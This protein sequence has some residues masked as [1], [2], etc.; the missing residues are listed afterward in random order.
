[1]DYPDIVTVVCIGDPVVSD[2]SS[3]ETD[4]LPTPSSSAELCGG[5][6]VVNTVDL[7]DLVVIGLRGRKQAVKQVSML[8]YSVFF[9]LNE[10][11]NVY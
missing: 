11:T 1:M 2:L 9:R 10:Y 6:H 7:I 4:K 5:T 8:S 3:T